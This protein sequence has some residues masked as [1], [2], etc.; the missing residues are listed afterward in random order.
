VFI[1]GHAHVIQRDVRTKLI[2]A[3]ALIACKPQAV[4][5]WKKAEKPVTFF[6]EALEQEIEGSP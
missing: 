1:I 2:L 5:I 4:C 3:T 6:C